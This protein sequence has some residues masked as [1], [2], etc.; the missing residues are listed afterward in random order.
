MKNKLLFLSFLLLSAFVQSQTYTTGVVSLSSSAGLAMTAKMDVGTQVTLT[1]TGPSG[2]WFALG[3][4]A[5]SMGTGNDVVMAHT[6]GTLSSFDASIGGYSAPTADPQQNWTI[7]SDAV[8]SGVR[9][10]VATRALITGDANDHDFTA[11][12]GSLSLIW[13]RAVSASYS[14]SYHG[15]SNRGISTATFT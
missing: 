11:A 12:T 4:D 10:I 3:F 2:R 1:L 5:T 9:T 14:F 13:A 15:S 8:A 6:A 7:V